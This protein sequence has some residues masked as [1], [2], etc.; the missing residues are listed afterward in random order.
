MNYL[1]RRVRAATRQRLRLRLPSRVARAGRWKQRASRGGTGQD[2]AAERGPGV[3]IAWPWSLPFFYGRDAVAA[4]I[5]FPISHGHPPSSV[6]RLRSL[7]SLLIV[8]V[9]SSHRASGR[10]WRVHGSPPWRPWPVPCQ[11]S[12]RTRRSGTLAGFASRTVAPVELATGWRSSLSRSWSLS[13]NGGWVQAR[14]GS[15]SLR[16]LT[17]TQS[18]ALPIPPIGVAV[19]SA[20]GPGGRWRPCSRESRGKRWRCDGAGI[21]TPSRKR[22]TQ[23]TRHPS[24]RMAGGV[25]H[26]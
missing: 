18:T 16:A 4:E 21:P 1:R 6:G 3:P 8:A 15:P 25:I 20:L 11:R 10:P 12:S 17:A 7:R 26:G 23:P 9:G 24:W 22:P 14:P 19:R 13:P 5:E 2:D